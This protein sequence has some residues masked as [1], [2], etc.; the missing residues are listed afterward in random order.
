MEEENDRLLY[1]QDQLAH[2]LRYDY[3]TELLNRQA[4]LSNMEEVQTDT[5]AA[6]H[7]VVAVL[8]CSKPLPKEDRVRIE[9]WLK[10]RT[11]VDSLRVITTH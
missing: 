8:G 4:A 7:Y 2:K 3:L 9:N 10:V 11:K 6:R 1:E 5:A